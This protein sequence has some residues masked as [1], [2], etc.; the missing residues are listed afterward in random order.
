LQPTP[1]IEGVVYVKLSAQILR[2]IGKAQTVPHRN[3]FQTR[4]DLVG[5]Q[6]GRNVGRVDDGRKPE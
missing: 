4:R 2:I 3:G 1:R 5:V 6:I